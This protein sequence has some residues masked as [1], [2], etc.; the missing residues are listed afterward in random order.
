MAV[1]KQVKK[2]VKAEDQIKAVYED[3]VAEINGT[4]YVFSKLKH[5]DRL[6][7][8]E[9]L[10]NATN[11][12]TGEMRIPWTSAQFTEVEALIN[13]KVLVDDMQISKYDSYWDQEE[14]LDDYMPFIVTAV[15]V[16]C[17]PF[18]RGKLGL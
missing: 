12:T 11:Q 4:Q 6:K 2:Q 15:Q 14:N 10:Q 5:K 18:M 1:K 8:F 16:I 17:Y 9:M 13:S 3:G 7:V